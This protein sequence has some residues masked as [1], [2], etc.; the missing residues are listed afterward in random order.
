[1]RLKKQSKDGLL[2]QEIMDKIMTEEKKEPI[3]VTFAGSKLRQYFPSSYTPQQME[4]VILK[5]LDGW[6]RRQVVS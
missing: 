3:K 6:H 4:A 5:L 1:M 2:T